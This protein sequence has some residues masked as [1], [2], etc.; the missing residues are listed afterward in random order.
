MP[1]TRLAIHCQLLPRAPQALPSLMPFLLCVFAWGAQ[2]GLRAGREGEHR[3]GMPWR[4]LSD[5]DLSEVSINKAALC[6]FKVLFFTEQIVEPRDLDQVGVLQR[7]V[8][9][10]IEGYKELLWRHKVT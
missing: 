10:K 6:I 8:S 4:E 3:A 1:T 2:G 7:P 5:A 9:V